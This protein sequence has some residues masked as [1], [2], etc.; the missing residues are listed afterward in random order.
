MSDEYQALIDCLRDHQNGGRR[1]ECDE[2][3]RAIETL[4]ARLSRQQEWIDAVM[5]QEFFVMPGNT[6]LII[7]PRP[8]AKE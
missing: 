4:R 1:G 5:G 3:A 2:A 8:L 6:R 7:R